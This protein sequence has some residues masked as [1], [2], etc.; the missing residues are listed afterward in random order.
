VT[1]TKHPDALKDWQ[2]FKELKRGGTQAADDQAMEAMWQAIE[3][4]RSKEDAEKVFNDTYKS[5]L[6]GK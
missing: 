5:V 2:A 1:I 4:G 6:N 3:Q